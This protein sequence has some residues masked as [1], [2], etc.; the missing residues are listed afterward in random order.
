[1]LIFVALDVLGSRLA[2]PRRLQRLVLQ[3]GQHPELPRALPRRRL[4]DPRALR[5]R[6]GRSARRGDREPEAQPADR[7]HRHGSDRRDLLHVR[8][9]GRARRSRHDGR[10]GKGDFTALRPDLRPRTTAVGRRVAARAVR[11][12]ELVARGL[13]SRSRTRRRACSSAW[14]GPARCRA[15]SAR[16]IPAG[17]TPWNAIWLITAITLVDRPR[18][19]LVVRAGEPVRDDRDLADARPDR[20]LLDGQPRRV[21]LLLRGERRSEFNW[22]LHFVIPLATSLALI[23]VAYKTI[24]GQHLLHPKSYARLPVLGRDRLDRPRRDHPDHREP[25]GQGSLAHEGRTSRLT[26]GPRP[27]RSSPTSRPI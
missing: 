26:C 14:A 6:V 17:K 7:D 20:R 3:P 19:R 12:R 8:E 22:F 18:S 5:V 24:E 13:A 15:C 11:D 4:H 1:M 10:H 23:W 25:H 21:P 27:P 9:L 2:G 16:C